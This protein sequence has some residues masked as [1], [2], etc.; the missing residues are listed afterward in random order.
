MAR[1]LVK[2]FNSEL[3][4]VFCAFYIVITLLGVFL[5]QPLCV[6]RSMELGR[7]TTS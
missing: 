3:A 7:S 1:A 2:R 6:E 5:V 4:L